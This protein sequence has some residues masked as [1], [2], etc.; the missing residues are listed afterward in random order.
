MYEIGRM[1]VKIAGR[2]AGK[3]CVI[4]DSV[5]DHMVLIDGQTRR[6]NCN[7]NHLE[8]LDKVLKI[9]RGAAHSAVV[10]ALKTEG[11]TVVDTQPKIN[12][13][14]TPRRRIY[15]SLRWNYPFKSY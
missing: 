2:D 5:N 12:L 13:G 7:V 14:Q 1:C 3:T 6:R 9:T 8:P 11:I 15:I 10:S 4:I